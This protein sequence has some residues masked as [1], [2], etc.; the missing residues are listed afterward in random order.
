MFVGTASA[1]GEVIVEEEENPFGDIFD[2]EN[3]EVE[4]ILEWDSLDKAELRMSMQ[5]DLGSYAGLMRGML[6]TDKDGKVEEDEIGDLENIFDDNGS[7]EGPL[8]LDILI[9]NVSAE[10]DLDSGWT[11]LL[12]DVDSEEPLGMYMT[13]TFTWTIDED[14]DRHTIVMRSVEPEEE[15]EEEWE[16]EN[17]T[18][19]DDDFEEDEGL[20]FNA[21]FVIDLPDGWDIDPD[22]VVPESM[23][24]YIKDDNTI[25]LTPEDLETIGE[26]EGDIVSLDIVKGGSDDSPLP[27]WLPLGALLV[28]ALSIGLLRRRKH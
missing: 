11:G 9:D 8:G 21:T 25:E 16:E 28:G 14:L 2:P 23:K 6:D 13:I 3:M 20:P 15:E 26:Q 27:I 19:P 7:E 5:M 4:I 24:D 18:I 1:Q 10:K 12:G 17:I 22:T